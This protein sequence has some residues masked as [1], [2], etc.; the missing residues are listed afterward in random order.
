MTSTIVGFVSFKPARRKIV[1]N[2]GSNKMEKG[3]LK[4]ILPPSFYGDA[5]HTCADMA[6]NEKHKCTRG[7]SGMLE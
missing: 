3:D 6:R 7:V 4:H 2:N 5:F 1:R